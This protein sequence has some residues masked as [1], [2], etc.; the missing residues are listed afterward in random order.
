MLF[1]DSRDPFYRSPFGAQPTDESVLVR[2]RADQA[3][4]AV[5]L[6]LWYSDGGEV[7]IAMEPVNLEQINM[8]PTAV[9]P[10]D[11]ALL[12]ASKKGARFYEARFQTNQVPGWV[13]YYFEAAVREN[14]PELPA[15]RPA[16]AQSG[17]ELPGSR[18][19]GTALAQRQSKDPVK[20]IYYGNNQ[21]QLGG[22]GAVYDEKP[23]AWQVTVYDRHMTVPAWTHHATMYHIFVDRFRRGKNSPPLGTGL[24]RDQVAHAH[25][26]DKPFYGR[27]HDGSVIQYDFFGGN[28]RG[29]MEKI[30]Y[31][32]SLGVTCLYLSPVMDSVSNHKYDV[33]NYKALDPAFGT[34]DDF[35]LFVGRAHGYGMKVIL[36]GVFS[37]TGADSLYFNA[38]GHYNSIGAAQSKG[39]PYY[40]WYRFDSYPN[41]YDCWWGITSMP[42]VWEGTPSYLNYMLYD[43]DS[44]IQYWHR[45]GTDGWRL[46]VADEL[47]DEFL[48]PFREKLRELG[49]EQ[50]I[51]GEVWEDASRKESYGK[52]RPYF[53]GG[54]LD[55]V[56]NY[57]FRQTVIDT[58]LGRIT[59]EEGLKQLDS[60]WENYPLP[61]FY[62]CMNLLSSHDER[63]IMTELGEA[64]NINGMNEQERRSF[65]LPLAKRK[66][67]EARLR[68]AALWQFTFPGMPDIY[69][70]DEVGLEGDKD[71]YN[72]GTFPWGRETQPLTAWYQKLGAWRRT[73]TVLRTGTY[74]SL[75]GRTDK[76]AGADENRQTT[77]SSVSAGLPESIIAYERRIQGGK[78]IFGDKA[79]NSMA[80]I[81]INPGKLPEKLTLFLEDQYWWQEL[82]GGQAYQAGVNTVVIPPLGAVIFA[83]RKKAVGASLAAEKTAPGQAAENTASEQAAEKIMP[84]WA[85]EKTAPGQTAV[86]DCGIL[87]HP[88]S[89]PSPDGIG[90]LGP[91]AY[92]WVD[93]L[94]GSGHTHWQVLPLTYPAE[95][96][97]PYTASSANAGDIRLISLDKLQEEGLLTENELKEARKQAPGEGRVDPEIVLAYKEPLLRKAYKRFCQD[98]T[99]LAYAAFVHKHEWWLLPYAVFQ[100]LKKQNPDEN[101]REWGEM[102]HPQAGQIAAA[103]EKAKE[104]TGY[105]YFLQ[106]CFHKQWQELHRHANDRGI[107]IIGDLPFFCA[108][109]SSDVWANQKLFDLKEDGSPHTVAGVPP[110][111]FSPEGQLWGNPHYRW[112]ELQKD[113]FQL[114]RRNVG[115]LLTLVDMVR[116]DHFRAYAA[117]WEVSGE[118]KTAVNGRW[119][120][121]PKEELF[122]AWEKEHGPLPGFAEDLGYITGDVDALR[123][124]IQMP[125]VRVLQFA[126]LDWRP[127]F[128]DIKERVLYTGT[129]DNE[130]LA[131]WLTSLKTA[132]ETE[133]AQQEKLAQQQKLAQLESA[134]TEAHLPAGQ[135]AFV[136]A[137]E[138][139][140]PGWLRVLT[141]LGFEAGEVKVEEV[142][143]ALLKEAYAMSSWLTIVP[144]QDIL[145]QGNESRMNE[146]G[147]VNTTNWLWRFGP[148]ELDEA[149]KK[150]LTSLVNLRR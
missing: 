57:P 124:A 66:C 12:A 83:G 142:A 116:L 45:R 43:Y 44:V 76:A 134:D 26:E 59:P 50:F 100:L 8:E 131:G 2:I 127:P 71:P 11:A 40:E 64:G 3:V 47:P 70:G 95:G 25:W 54:E 56:M 96:N 102:A 147:T 140:V 29:I 72:R 15:E 27:D 78:D 67:A 132:Y 4:S 39:S 130:T 90:D 114:W 28:I 35:R 109:E 146:P 136:A 20:H 75:S 77:S 115:H 128:D 62:S 120:S 51:L 63:R 148:E 36:D 117:Y 108:A 119:V 88:T 79:E 9:D 141:Y 137:E 49:S 101:W 38:F 24:K 138:P 55:G 21:E 37:H 91:E 23:P 92:A 106:W 145:L 53:Q 60:L 6:C 113:G 22:I 74:R 7:R 68:L 107:S 126:L 135:P 1:H 5:E 30:P 82:V 17:R 52:L 42:N 73:W 46:D 98:R 32:H 87:L 14:Q 99:G 111:Y 121:G 94:A 18:P 103:A 48:L 104:E 89:L 81:Y 97:S 65:A 110:D 144:L 19:L 10:R 125:G 118:E 80:R 41:S 86:R 84:S 33:G 34:D 149:A 139:P 112:Q 69:Y 133:L 129:H 150:R 31:L 16:Q 105:E 13:W 93:T 85:V 122:M 123:Q 61:V 58:L 143:E